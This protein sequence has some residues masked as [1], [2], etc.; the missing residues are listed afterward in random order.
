MSLVDL[1][2]GPADGILRSTGGS[3]PS[4][5]RAIL[6]VRSWIEPPAVARV[7]WGSLRLRADEE[8]W[9]GEDDLAIFW[10]VIPHRVDCRSVVE[11]GLR[12]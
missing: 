2:S 5:R 4:G 3:V 12:R 6:A 9:H 7:R 11:R 8:R 1:P 10:K